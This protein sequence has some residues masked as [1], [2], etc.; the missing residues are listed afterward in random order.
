M[1]QANPDENY[2]NNLAGDRNY[3]ALGGWDIKRRHHVQIGL[4]RVWIAEEK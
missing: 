4:Q 3:S 2:F 1:D